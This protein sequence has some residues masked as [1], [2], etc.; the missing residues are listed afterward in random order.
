MNVPLFIIGDS[1]ML[2]KQK[3][4]KQINKKHMEV[5]NANIFYSNIYI[6]IDTKLD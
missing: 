2:S 5:I 4:L 1:G 6:S 3:N